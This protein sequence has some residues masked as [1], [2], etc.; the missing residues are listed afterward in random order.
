MLESA[1]E[2]SNKND[3][4]G[5]LLTRNSSDV[6]IVDAH[7]AQSETGDDN[8]NG[9]PLPFHEILGQKITNFKVQ[10]MRNSEKSNHPAPGLITAELF[11]ESSEEM[12]PSSLKKTPMSGS[13]QGNGKNSNIHSSFTQKS[14][15]GLE[16][17]ISGNQISN[18]VPSVAI[19]SETFIEYSQTGI[20]NAVQNVSLRHDVAGV[21]AR[22]GIDTPFV[23]HANG[24][25]SSLFSQFTGQMGE[26]NPRQNE[27]FVDAN[28]PGILY[29][30]ETSLKHSQ[31]TENTLL[32]SDIV[33]SNPTQ[34]LEGLQK[35]DMSIFSMMQ[36]SDTTDADRN[37]IN[38]MKFPTVFK[39]LAQN[40]SAENMHNTRMMEIDNPAD[41]AVRHT[42]N[43]LSKT[44]NK[45]LPQDGI[46][47][48]PQTNEEWDLFDRSGSKQNTYDLANQGTDI[49][50]TNSNVPF[51][52]DNQTTKDD[53]Q[54]NSPDFQQKTEIFPG[55]DVIPSSS[56]EGRNNNVSH[57]F[58]GSSSADGEHRYSNSIEQFFKEIRLMNHGDKISL[59][60]HGDRS[61]IKLSLTPPE[62]GSVEIHFTQE[63]DEIEAK[64]F[65][66]NAEVKAAIED[67]VH[68]LK[69]SVAASGLEIQKLEVYIQNDNAS[70]EKSF[71]NSDAHNQP[72]QT[73]GQEWMN[74]EHSI[75]E[76]KRGN[77]VQQ[78]ISVKTS[79]VMVDYII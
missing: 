8:G 1:M 26:D 9:Y 60:N 64:I 12:D 35:L 10:D 48:T 20:Q 59:V 37:A 47:N 55:S 29:T 51:S 40:L 18:T 78:E 65:V 52:L 53:T 68:R 76:G 75:D 34:K 61:E 3:L 73:R 16:Q 72:Y 13:S 23:S 28:T 79:D 50:K 17:D 39:T 56:L 31:N 5:I 62:L 6:Q 63:N 45:V 77:N 36:E 11:P 7:G 69:E 57:T 19:L 43:D 71:D 66:E 2:L 25:D 46:L 15:E 22:F 38:M 58:H 4:L 42:E 14:E 21:N 49:Q 74:G 41:T 54:A 67:N 24:K 27:V 44:M 30:G 33:G 32:L 70:K